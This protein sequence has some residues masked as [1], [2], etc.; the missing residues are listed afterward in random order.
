MTE[1]ASYLIQE[2]LK[3]QKM[4]YAMNRR[5]GIYKCLDYYAGDNTAQYIEDRFSADAFQ[6]IPV[7]EF[8]VTRRMIDRM[9]RIYTMGAE[10]NVN[11]KYDDMTLKKPYKIMILKQ[12]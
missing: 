5:E 8:N 1:Q 10:R 9:S 12:L 11:T 3:E 6:E 2:S 7:S 4:L